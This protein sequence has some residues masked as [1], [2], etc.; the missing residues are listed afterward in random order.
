MVGHDE[1][2]DADRPAEIHL[3]RQP[4]T[5]LDGLELAPEGLRKSPF[6]QSLEAALELLQSHGAISLPGT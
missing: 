5:Q 1:A 6:D 3:A 4:A 2:V